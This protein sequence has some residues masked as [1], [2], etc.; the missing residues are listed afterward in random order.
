[1]GGIS[2]VV[3]DGETE[4]GWP[5][6]QS[7]TTNTGAIDASGP[8]DELSTA[9]SALD[10][11]VHSS[12]AIVDDVVYV[13]S[14][15]GSVYALDADDGDENWSL[16]IG[17]GVDSS[18]VVDQGVVYV[19]NDSGGLFAI[20]AD[21]G[22]EVW[23]HTFDVG[24]FTESAK[25]VSTPAISDGYVFAHVGNGLHAHDATDGAEQWNATS[26]H[27]SGTPPAPTV[28]GG[29]VYVGAGFDDHRGRGGYVRGFDVDDGTE[30]FS[31][32]FW[33]QADGSPAVEDDTLYLGGGGATSGYMYAINVET[34]SEEWRDDREGSKTAPTVVD[35]TVYFG[36]S[37]AGIGSE[38]HVVAL[39]A[40]TNEEKWTFELAH[41]IDGSPAVV[42]GRVYATDYY[43]NVYTLDAESGDLLESTQLRDP[44]DSSTMFT[45]PVV[46]GDTVYLGANVFAS[47]D[48]TFYALRD[49]D[50][51]VS[52]DLEVA[53]ATLSDDELKADESVTITVK[54]ANDGD[55][56]GTHTAELEVDGDVEAT[57]T[58]SVDGGSTTEV[59]FTHTFDETGEFDVHVDGLEAGT[60][61][62]TAD[63]ESSQSP[64]PS[65]PSGSISGPSS[66]PPLD[67]VSEPVIS[68]DPLESG[69]AVT[70]TDAVAHE[71]TAISLEDGAGTDDTSLTQLAVTPATDTDFDVTVVTSDDLSDD[72]DELPD[73]AALLQALEVESSLERDEIENATFEFVV[74]ADELE[75][76]GLEPEDVTLYHDVDGEWVE[77]ETEIAA[78]PGDMWEE[79]G[80]DHPEALFPG[81]HWAETEPAEDLFPGD[82]WTEA[83]TAEDLFPGD[84]WEEAGVDDP[85][86]LFPEERI[87]AAE[88]AEDLFPG[89][90]WAEAETAEDLF[91]GDHWEEAGVD[92]PDALFPGDT[93][94]EAETA[95]DLFPS[96]TWEEAETAEDLFPGDT[97]E[98]AETAEDLFP[99]D[100]WEE[101]YPGDMW[102]TVTYEAETPHFS[103]FALAA[104]RPGLEVDAPSISPTEPSAGEE[105]TIE[106]TVTND[107]STPDEID[108]LLEV[109]GTVVTTKTVSLEPDEK[110]LVT[111]THTF[112]EPGVFDVRVG[113]LEVG[114]VTVDAETDEDGTGDDAADEG[115]AAEDGTDGV[116][117]FGVLVTVAVMLVVATLFAA[118]TRSTRPRP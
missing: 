36:N 18:P 75:E 42:D 12:P 26:G 82:H 114:T 71:P 16:E 58:V 51:L 97:W 31:P 23:A 59:T 11:H 116:P 46:T 17:D 69:A 44:D 115:G 4:D 106:T 113:D 39:N 87:E 96:D 50:G 104:D 22:D 45:S 63:E 80:A 32:T 98:E 13:G 7:D 3:A 95:E 68:V 84:H 86:A 60:V 74:T 19:G 5:Q 83:E 27:N 15:D 99:G 101:A 100:T 9:W 35:E 108:L 81:D 25:A 94:E 47:D 24:G 72:V 76:R 8:E 77:R 66:L 6:Y 38:Y 20:D 52:P 70:V 67:P 10:D 65:V 105:L 78:Y 88:K 54:I 53:S 40:T 48:D 49:G 112:D 2:G 34:E 90:H 55:A 102:D 91:P 1:M 62:V 117:G 92:D 28:A 89:D 103:A 64:T 57:E 37:E 109:D 111:F 29:V 61:T 73:D 33:P 107:R 43:G 56:V 79:A 93:W 14:N 110:R 85:D 21:T 30:V 41:R 118:V